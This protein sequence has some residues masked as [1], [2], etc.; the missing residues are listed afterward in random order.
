MYINDLIK[1]ADL[2]NCLQAQTA[3]YQT[4][5]SNKINL[6]TGKPKY[7]EKDVLRIC[8]DWKLSTKWK[9]IKSLTTWIL[10]TDD[11]QN[12]TFKI[13]GGE[14]SLDCNIIRNTI[15]YQFHTES[16]AAGGHHIQEWHKR[17]IVKSNLDKN[18]NSS[19][20]YTKL[21]VLNNL[22]LLG[23]KIIEADNKLMT[24][25][26]MSPM[27][28]Y[29]TFMRLKNPATWMPEA[30]IVKAGQNYIRMLQNN[31]EALRKQYTK[32]QEKLITFNK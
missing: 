18:P 12:P 22:D 16:I 19:K 17:Y 15:A 25:T 29:M 4:R 30:E 1:L 32:L 2:E 11:I 28:R 5:L 6:K 31:L 27:E 13:L 10:E 14:I 20:T 21:T 3:I 9:L 26:N 24:V 8:E 23:H 7:S